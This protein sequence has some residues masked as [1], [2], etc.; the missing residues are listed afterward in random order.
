LGRRGLVWQNLNFREDAA[1]CDDAEFQ[2]F[3]SQ[4]LFFGYDGCFGYWGYKRDLPGKIIRW[5]D[6]ERMPT[7][8]V[9]GDHPLDGWRTEKQACDAVAAETGATPGSS[10]DRTG[11]CHEPEV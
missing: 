10:T 3:I 6:E 11:V 5:G 7:F 8:T 1:S 9:V 4:C 2:T